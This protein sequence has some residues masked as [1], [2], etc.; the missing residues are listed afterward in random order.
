[1]KYSAAQIGAFVPGAQFT[2]AGSAAG[3]LAGLTFGVKDLIDVEGVVTGAG[4]PRWAE[5]HAPAARDAS[6]VAAM[7]AAG[8][9]CVGKTITDEL[10]YSIG[11][12]NVHY[13]TPVNV[14]APGCTP[15]G[16]SS[17][18]AA[19]VAAGLCDF[20]LASDTGGSTRL[21]SS[22][23]G[24]YGM[25]T[26]HGAIARDGMVPLMPSFDTLTW[27][28]ASFGVF[29]RVGDVL[30]PPVSAPSRPSRLLLIADGFAVADSTVAAALAPAVDWLTR[31]FG[32]A[33]SITAFPAGLEELRVAYA[34]M[35]G[36]EA[37]QVHGEWITRNQPRFSDS[38]A[39]RFRYSSTISADQAA[40]ANVVREKVKT[41]M[42]QLL[43]PGVIAVM[44]SAPCTAL[45]ISATPEEAEHTRQ[46]IFR[47]TSI[48]GLAGL[49]QMSVP[50]ARVAGRPAGLSLLAAPGSDRM[51]VEL[52]GELA[53][54]LGLP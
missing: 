47:M 3:P 21:P 34:V 20:A 6:S 1:M 38:I 30:L 25:R 54:A 27:V 50:V 33:A 41:R 4:N 37:W 32:E 23:S 42:R 18:S 24:L 15:G 5:T 39:A 45:P 51:L 10:A 52:A 2:R 8:A 14:N 9:T 28:A 53:A 43:E 17:G 40:T 44:P 11:G 31:R 7:L 22:Y 49:P 36:Y 13:G 16:S 26:T 29:S 35:S 19:A 12:D 48:A 46:R